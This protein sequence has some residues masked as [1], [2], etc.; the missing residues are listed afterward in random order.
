MLP[1]CDTP[2]LAEFRKELEKCTLPHSI[3][4]GDL[5]WLHKKGS[6][7]LVKATGRYLGELVKKYPGIF[8]CETTAAC[9]DGAGKQNWLICCA[10][11]IHRYVDD[12]DKIISIE[13]NVKN[14]LHYLGYTKYAGPPD[15]EQVFDVNLI[16]QRKG[17]GLG[18]CTLDLWTPPRSK[19]ELPDEPASENKRRRGS[20]EE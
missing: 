2:A 3:V 13:S 18:V 7:P 15:D 6:V 20:S 14:G 8:L 5:F 10:P 4:C 9:P 12:E 16:L 17:E 11:F 19:R 1:N